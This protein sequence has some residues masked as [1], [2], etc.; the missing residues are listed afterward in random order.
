MKRF[1]KIMLI[2]L[3]VSLIIIAG[4]DETRDYLKRKINEWKGRTA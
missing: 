2:I 4:D 1:V 3:L